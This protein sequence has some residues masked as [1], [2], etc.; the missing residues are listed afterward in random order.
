[1]EVHRFVAE[2]VLVGLFLVCFV[3]LHCFMLGM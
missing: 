1:M 3:D 2:V